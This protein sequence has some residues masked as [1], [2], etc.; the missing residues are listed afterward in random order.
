[1]RMLIAALCLCLTAPWA[2]SAQEDNRAFPA[3]MSWRAC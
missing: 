2:A 1:M 3:P